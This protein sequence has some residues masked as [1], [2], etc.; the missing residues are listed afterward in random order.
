[1]TAFQTRRR[2]VE[3]KIILGRFQRAPDENLIRTIAAAHH[4]LDA[5]RAGVSMAQTARRFGRTAA[6][7]RQRA[8][9]ALLAPEITQASLEGRQPPELTVKKLLQTDIPLCW[10]AQAKL[11]GFER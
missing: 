1:E 7:L 6:V 11:L 4:W 8:P 9:L 10:R 5:L 2:G 3:Q